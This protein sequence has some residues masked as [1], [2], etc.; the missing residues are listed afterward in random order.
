[1]SSF[2]P[3]E[4]QLKAQGG[5]VLAAVAKQAL[6]AV[7]FVSERGMCQKFVR[8]VIQAARG[9]KY[10]Q[11]HGASAEQSR[12]LWQ[13][14]PFAVVPERGSV[15]GDILYKRA[16]DG[17]PYGHVGIR[18]AGNRVAENSTV[19]NGAFGGRGIRLLENFGKPDLIVRLP[20]S[21]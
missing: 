3:T 7:G 16:H 13:A 9:R 2:Q 17:Q 4:E 10:D 18:I 15:I 8:Q 11:F 20:Q 5:N 19:H 1:M 21:S 14:S 6:T 12:K